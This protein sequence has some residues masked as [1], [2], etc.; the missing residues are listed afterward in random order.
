MAEQITAAADE[1]GADSLTIIDVGGDALTKWSRP[2][3]TQPLADQLAIAACLRS[4]LPGRLIIAAPGVVRYPV[5][6]GQRFKDLNSDR[7]QP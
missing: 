1:F 5:T 4:G 7:L 6:L 3:T 2:W